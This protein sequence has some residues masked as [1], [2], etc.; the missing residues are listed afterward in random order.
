[1]VEKGVLTGEAV[2]AAATEGGDGGNISKVQEEAPSSV[3]ELHT[4]TMEIRPN[5][6]SD[7]KQENGNSPAA[8]DVV[9]VIHG[10]GRSGA[11]ISRA[12]GVL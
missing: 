2:G 5:L 11:L 9:R 4:S 10:G 1:V 8:A 7:E 3:P 6:A 12:K